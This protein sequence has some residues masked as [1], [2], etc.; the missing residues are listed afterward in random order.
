MRLFELME[1]VPPALAKEEITGIGCDSRQVQKG[2][3][4]FCIAGA[5]SDGHDYAA[6][7]LAAGA[8]AVVA[9]RD[10]GLDRQ[11][12]VADTHAAYATACA[13]WFGNPA[14]GLRLIGV[15]GT[16]GKTSV[17]YLLKAILE[18]AGEQV[19][20]VGTI[21]NMI[22]DEVIAAHNTTPSAYE[23]HSL[24]ALMRKKGCTYCIMEVSSHALDQ[25]R[26]GGLTFDRAIFTN[27]TQDHLDYH[28]TM[29]R[30]MLAK[31]RL[32]EMCRKAVINADDAYSQ[33]LVAGLDCEIF[34]YSASADDA[35]YTAKNIVYR[36][37]GVSY[38][39]VGFGTIGH[40]KLKTAGRFS[41]Y[42]SMAAAVTALSLGIPMEHLTAALRELAGVKG[43]A[44]V[45]PCDKGFTVI[46]DYAHTPDGLQNILSTF[47]DCPKNRLVVLFGCGGDRDRGK[48]PK[49]GSIAARYADFV[50]VT[51]DNPRS[52]DPSAIIDD[53]LKGMEGTQTPYAVVEN[54]AEAIRYAIRNALP[55]DILI[56]AG[57]GHETY[58]VLREGTI[59]L[60]EREI[61]AEALLALDA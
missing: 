48:R 54:R 32:F 57:K 14:E 13:R 61:V 36:P 16:N 58:Q 37:D 50:V 42:N 52:E 59:H 23:L 53:I 34:T 17:T 39:L 22:G 49:M 4:F 56:L 51:S 30:Y 35:T 33:R 25:K 46:I 47:K 44:E 9:E 31:R 38:E 18:A 20:L 24:F 19:G 8:V 27:L 10:L 1:Q 55:G 12:L 28:G 21:Q 15:T 2:Y 26:V 41:V 43:R 45:V 5:K 40:I 60:D 29:E 3:V 11:I 6:Q 7:A